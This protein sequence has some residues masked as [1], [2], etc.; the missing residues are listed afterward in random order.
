MN[1]TTKIIDGDVG[2]LSGSEISICDAG[3][4]HCAPRHYY[5]A[6]RDY[7]LFHLVAEGKGVFRA[8]EECFTLTAGDAFLIRPGERCSYTAD[9]LDPW[10][11]LWI[12]F[13]GSDAEKLVGLAAGDERVFSVRAESIAEIEGALMDHGDPT[14]LLFRLKGF[15][16]RF[17]GTL[18]A[19]RTG[20]LNLPD[21]IRKAVIYMREHYARSFSVEELSAELGMSRS[22]FTTLF[23]K[24]VGVPPHEYLTA[25]RMERAKEE[26]CGTKSVS[27]IAFGV[28]YSSVERFSSAF[29]R[30]EGMSPLKYRKSRS[31]HNK[32]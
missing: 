22:H 15:I 7:W 16:F 5:G 13:R 28:G 1:E 18:Y 12:G 17:F 29:K 31:P 26:L 27:E 4:E 11:Y 3:F 6:V 10:Y 32:V 9:A 14:E 19:K 20:A 8:G 25:L 21:I 2:G 24:T 23:K 30:C